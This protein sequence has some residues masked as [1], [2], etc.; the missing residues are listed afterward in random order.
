MSIKAVYGG[1][2]IGRTLYEDEDIEKAYKLLEEGGCNTIDTARIYGDSEEWLGKTG[3][4]K[5]FIIDSKAPGGSHRRQQHQH[6]H[7]PVRQGDSRAPPVPASVDVYYLHA[8]DPSVE[9]EDQLKGITKH[10]RRA[11]FQA[12]RH[13]GTIARSLESRKS[14]SSRLC[15]L[16]WHVVYSPTAGGLLT[17]T[18]QQ[19]SDGEDA[20]RFAKGHALEGLY[21]GLYKQ[22]VALQ[23]LDLWGGKSEGPLDAA[24]QSWHIVGVAFDSPSMPSMVTRLSSGASKHSQIAGN[25][26][27]LKRGSVGEAAKAKI[28]EI[29]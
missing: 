11:N 20:G 29:W 14:S 13:Q 21:G 24:G 7:T 22:A 28:E 18:A 17:R 16:E 1:A 4:G 9:L 10:T 26:G 3:A 6:D 8:P 25:A 23:A 5:R 12:L 19:L 15:K 27:W 2:S